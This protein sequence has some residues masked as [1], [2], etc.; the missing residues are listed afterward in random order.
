VEEYRNKR[1]DRVG[2]TRCL[3]ELDNNRTQD[4]AYGMPS[5]L[6]G[7]GGKPR[8]T[9]K[10]IMNGYYMESSLNHSTVNPI[11]LMQERRQIR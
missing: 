5:G 1:G 2:L 6:Q 10:D 7:A 4:L 11:H 9:A 8:E 3:D